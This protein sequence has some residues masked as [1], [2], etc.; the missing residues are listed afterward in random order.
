MPPV[1]GTDR[2]GRNLRLTG[3]DVLRLQCA[4]VSTKPA[5]RGPRDKS[6]LVA[7][8]V[9]P[10]KPGSGGELN[11]YRPSWRQA[12]NTVVISDQMAA[13]SFNEFRW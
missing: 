10:H 13:L 9:P 2:V 7:S 3:Q 4:S 11:I 5:L 12:A 8:L 1:M 6:G